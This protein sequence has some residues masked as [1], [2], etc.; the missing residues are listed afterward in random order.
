MKV[1]ILT[2]PLK[3]NYG[4]ILQAYA[5]QKTLR[6]FGCQVVTVDRQRNKRNIVVR[7]FRPLKPVIY[8]I[9]GKKI[10]R[11]LSPAKDEYVHA[12]MT[13]FIKRHISM[14]PK[15][16]SNT[17]LAKHFVLNRYDA[18]V[19]GSDQVWRPIYSPDI[20]NFFCDFVIDDIN[21]I[22]YSASFGVSSWEYTD[23]QTERCRSL[24]KKF[25]AVSVREDSGV[26]LC[27]EKFE[28]DSELVL[29]PT[30]LVNKGEYEEL[31]GNKKSEGSG[32]IFKY[33]LDGSPLKKE[34]VDAISSKLGKSVFTTYPIKSLSDRSISDW[35]DYR[36]PAVEEWLDSFKSAHFV[37]TDSF[38][39]C[40]FSIIFN[41]PF[42]VID[43][44]ARGNARLVSL[45]NIFGLTERL[46]SEGSVIAE[47]R[48]MEIDWIKVNKIKQSC[49]QKSVSFLLRNLNVSQD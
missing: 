48:L 18:I 19:V 41:K 5:L 8:D 26:L 47:L 30:L 40:A 27:R 35:S 42:V 11:W 17:K 24:I 32:K 36:F 37:V 16:D 33:I 29:D 4:G 12:G 38:H 49:Q 6:E 9:F 20:Y 46:V 13:E 3:N 23:E 31:I 44:K 7:L 2:Q 14:T 25:K 1:A 28:V 34:V 21:I 10:G 15:I 43:N 39:G 22:S 45:L